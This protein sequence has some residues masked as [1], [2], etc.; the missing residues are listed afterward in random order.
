MRKI[1]SDD[2]YLKQVQSTHVSPWAGLL[3]MGDMF[4]ALEESEASVVN[5]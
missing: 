4:V 1:I 2:T 5:F 3:S